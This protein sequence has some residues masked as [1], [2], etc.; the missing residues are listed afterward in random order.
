LL[1]ATTAGCGIENCGSNSRQADV[2]REGT[3]VDGGNAEADVPSASETL[4]LRLARA[5]LKEQRFDLLLAE[6][7][8][9]DP[10]E[11]AKIQAKLRENRAAVVKIEK[12]LGEVGLPP[13]G[14]DLPPSLPQGENP[15]SRINKEQDAGS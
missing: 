7:V 10:A 6:S 5:A 1:F 12:Q 13:D 14:P 3:T 2:S 8:S 11:L 4:R 15:R 9:K